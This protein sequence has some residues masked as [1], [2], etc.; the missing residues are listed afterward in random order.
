M[1]GLDIR[2]FAR[3]LTRLP[4]PASTHLP[5]TSAAKHPRAYAS[6]VERW[7]FVLLGSVVLDLFLAGATLLPAHWLTP[8]PRLVALVAAVLWQAK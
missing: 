3:Q 2:S 7:G 5:G 8:V 4:I 1:P 6:A